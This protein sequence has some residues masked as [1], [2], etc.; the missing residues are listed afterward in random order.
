MMAN[1]SYTSLYRNRGQ[2]S[3]V[4]FVACLPSFLLLKPWPRAGIPLE[5]TTGC[6]FSPA[7]AT[8]PGDFP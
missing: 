2:L 4:I 6:R 8:R 7:D 5:T 3:C 1:H